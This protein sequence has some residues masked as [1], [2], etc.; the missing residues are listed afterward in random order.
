MEH[1]E[2]PDPDGGVPVLF[3]A[4]WFWGLYDIVSCEWKNAGCRHRGYCGC[5][6]VFVCGCEDGD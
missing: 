4:Y 3:G 5:L 6:H 1:K 2:D